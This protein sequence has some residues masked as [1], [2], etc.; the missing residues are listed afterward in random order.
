MDEEKN[1]VI[2]L[3]RWRKAPAPKEEDIGALE[4]DDIGAQEF[5]RSAPIIAAAYMRGNLEGRMQKWLELRPFILTLILSNLL[6]IALIWW[7]S[8]IR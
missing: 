4:E 8:E 1:N 3:D 7:L 2:P 5:F 6:S